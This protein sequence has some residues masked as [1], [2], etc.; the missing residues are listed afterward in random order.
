MLKKR[1]S[2]FKAFLTLISKTFKMIKKSH[3]MKKDDIKEKSLIDF[4]RDNKVS[5]V[6]QNI[7]NLRAHFERRESL[8]RHL[9]ILPSYMRGRKVVEI[10][11][12]SGFNSLYTAY[13]APSSYLL[14]EGNPK[15]VEEIESL[16]LKYPDLR[17]NI[18]IEQTILEE[19]K[20]SE[21]FDFVLC[22]GVL[23]GTRN[24]R[25]IIK[26]CAELVAPGGVLVLT[27]EDYISFFPDLLR[28]LL[29]NL[30]TS[31]NDDLNI[32]L[33]KLL[34]VFSPHLSKLEGMSRLH[35]D[36][37]I[38]NLINPAGHLSL[39]SIP[40]AISILSKD[41][42]IYYSSPQFFTDWRW[43]K[44]LKGENKNFNKRAISQ[45][46]QNSH[47]LID[48]DSVFPPI[49]EEQ[50]KKLYEFCKCT[51]KNIELL[52]HTQDMTLLKEIEKNLEQVINLTNLFSSKTGNAFREVLSLLRTQPVNGKAVAQSKHFSSLFAR[53]M[54]YLSFHKRLNYEL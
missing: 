29:S 32:K 12:G 54:Q 45:Y 2:L 53:G 39:T 4:Y 10:G 41:F 42:D 34:P 50:N 38:D 18:K 23:S 33:S 13:L 5:P 48:H 15:G 36:W 22:E 9:G 30:I 35:E 51:A 40:E 52:E 24:P 31:P 21:T 27:C 49:S 37:I 19:Y 20:T 3:C 26:K 17:K 1:C 6:R 46:W 14:I 43:Y 8:Y 16:F 7:E 11:P 25:Q 47:N 28:R 44:M